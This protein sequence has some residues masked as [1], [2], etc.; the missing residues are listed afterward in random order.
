MAH[1]RPRYARRCRSSLDRDKPDGRSLHR[2]FTMPGTGLF[3]N[4]PDLYIGKARLYHFL[5]ANS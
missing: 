4:P 3:A 1:A 5:T 2:R